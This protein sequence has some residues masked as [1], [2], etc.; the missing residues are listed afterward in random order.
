MEIRVAS[1]PALATVNS[2]QR[3]LHQACRSQNPRLRAYTSSELALIHC[4]Q[5]GPAFKQGPNRIAVGPALGLEGV[6]CT[7]SQSLHGSVA[8][9]RST[10]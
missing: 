2:K 7:A 4:L 6:K 8:R 5:K 9:P 3:A 10:F 1:P